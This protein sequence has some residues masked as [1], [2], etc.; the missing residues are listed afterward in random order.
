MPPILSLCTQKLMY[1]L[2]LLLDWNLIVTY[3]KFNNNSK[4]HVE[5]KKDKSHM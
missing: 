2:K 1:F 4:N 3:N 5:H